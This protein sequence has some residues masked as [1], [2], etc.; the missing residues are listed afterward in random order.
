MPLLEQLL[1]TVRGGW[2]FRDYRRFEFEPSRNEHLWQLGAELRKRFNEHVSVALVI[3]YDYFDSKN[4][5]FA[6]ERYVG[7]VVVRF[8]N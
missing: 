7:G 2:G 4:V 8:E 6:A 5:L 3:D 1:L